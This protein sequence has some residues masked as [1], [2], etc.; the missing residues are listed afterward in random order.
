MSR[1]HV[2]AN[3]LIFGHYSMSWPMVYTTDGLYILEM[4]NRFNRMLYVVLGE[5]LHKVLY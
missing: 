5:M 1:I 4:S 3:M 2:G